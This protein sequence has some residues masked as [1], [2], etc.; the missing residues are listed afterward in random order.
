MPAAAVMVAVTLIDVPTQS[1]FTNTLREVVTCMKCGPLPVTNGEKGWL[2]F[3]RR[4]GSLDGTGV[5]WTLR[6]WGGGPKGGARQAT[7]S[8]TQHTAMAT[9]NKPL[10]KVTSFL[11][12]V[13]PCGQVLA[14]LCH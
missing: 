7:N 12:D 14:I 10:G 1:D 6:S 8:P 2:L 13:S 5:G 11:G 4:H 9:P 3:V